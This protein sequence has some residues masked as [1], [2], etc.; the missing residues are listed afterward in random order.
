MTLDP[1]I[2]TRTQTQ[3]RTRRRSTCHRHPNEP[4][5][6]LCALCLR[7]RLAFL[8]SSSSNQPEIKH[9]NIISFPLSR[10]TGGH[11][12][13]SSSGS[14]PELRRSKS[15]AVEKCEDVLNGGGSFDL[16]R[17]SC[18]VRVSNN[19]TD[20]FHIEDTNSGSDR[21]VRVE[22]K[23]LGFIEP[24]LEIIEDNDDSSQVRVSDEDLMTMKEHIEME[25]QNKKKKF[26]DS[27]SV[28]GHKL[29]KWRQKHKE[30]KQIEVGTNSKKLKLVQCK[31]SQIQT[32]V[33]DYGGLGR[34]SCDTAPRFSIDIHR[35]SVEDHQRFSLDE[36]RASWDGY[37]IART[38]PRLTPMLPIV[39]N[40]ML[41]PVNKGIAVKEDVSSCSVSAKSKS[42]M[43][44]SNTGSSSS[45]MK[46]SSS[47]TAGLESLSRVNDVIGQETKLVITEKELKDWHLSS[48]KDNNVEY[49]SNA[50]T[51]VKNSNGHN[52]EMNSRWR[53]MSSLWSDKYKL[54][55]KKNGD[56]IRENGNR[57]NETNGV[58][59]GNASA[60]LVRNSSMVGSRNRNESLPSGQDGARHSMSDID[61]GL[62]KLYL[63][64]FTKSRKVKF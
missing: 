56:S 18:D 28:F 53:K 47:K 25:L 20:L 7:D 29:R 31:D 1:Q 55:D 43:C 62:L 34:K 48:I 14:V 51:T 15:V 13:A 54:G 33:P 39:D 6:G 22:S 17:K 50:R 37:M 52:K 64:P 58:E 24:V 4:I 60:K 21:V 35:M 19:L 42:D 3:T 63:S 32:E 11:A 9:E 41:P 8:D 5:T 46:S 36:H 27:A 57:N 30:K 23:N 12:G 16:R 61:S 26:W 40:I 44:S 59:R 49:A 45:S 2:R 10:R 38:I